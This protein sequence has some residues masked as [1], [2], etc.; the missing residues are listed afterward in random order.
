[1]AEP[2]SLILEYLRAMR[3][4]LAAHRDDLADTKACLDRIIASTDRWLSA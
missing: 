2:H 4:D 1:M 3:G